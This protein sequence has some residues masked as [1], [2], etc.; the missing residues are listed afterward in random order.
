[1]RMLN[2]LLAAL[3]L[4]TTHARHNARVYIGASNMV[5]A[6]ETMT[7]SASFANA[8][9]GF[10]GIGVGIDE[11]PHELI[12]IER[13]ESPIVFGEYRF[14]DAENQNDFDIEVSSFGYIHHRDVG[15]LDRRLT[16]S[17]AECEAI[18]RLIRSFFA[19][20]DVF[21]KTFLPPARYLGGLAFTPGWILRASDKP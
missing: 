10:G 6:A 18:E 15:T 5:M 9:V 1:M 14:L 17:V 21:K 2:T 13:T 3:L 19:N 8:R 20:P 4:S 7:N 16:F 11:E 12:K